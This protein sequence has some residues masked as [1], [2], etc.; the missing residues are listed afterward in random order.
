MDV[1]KSDQ[2][3]SFIKVPFT[4]QPSTYKNS[5]LIGLYRIYSLDKLLINKAQ[6]QLFTELE[7]TNS[8]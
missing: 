2:S 8:N 6:E 3:D 5:F 7:F 1:I 4:H